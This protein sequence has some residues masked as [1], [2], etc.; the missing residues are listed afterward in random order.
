MFSEFSRNAPLPEAYSLL[1]W[2]FA[3]LLVMGL[4]PYLWSKEQRN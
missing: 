4:I 3:A 1:I 2:V